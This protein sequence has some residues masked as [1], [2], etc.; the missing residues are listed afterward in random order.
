MSNDTKTKFE[1]I[2]KLSDK[3]LLNTYNRYPVAFEYGVGEMIFDQDNKGYIDFLAGIA[4]S[5]LGHGEADLI[6]AMRNQM[7][8]IL[9]S[10]NLYYSEEQAKLAEVIIENS[11]PG[12][13]FLCNSELRQRSCFQTHA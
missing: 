4:V 2:K 7:D 3:Y 5:N 9:H 12:K 8:K 10:S 13:V 1:E 6:E 11:I